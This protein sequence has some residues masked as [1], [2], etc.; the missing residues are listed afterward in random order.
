MGESY[1]G[2]TLIIAIIDIILWS[3]AFFLLYLVALSGFLSLIITYQCLNKLGHK[4]RK[5]EEYRLN[6]KYEHLKTGVFNEIGKFIMGFTIPTIVLGTFI[7]IIGLF[8]IFSGLLISG[9]IYIISGLVL[10]ALIVFLLYRNTLKIHYAITDTKSQILK[11]VAK[12]IQTL[13]AKPSSEIELPQKYEA[14]LN[15]VSFYDS[16]EEITDWPFDPASI[17]KLLLTLASS[18]VPLGLS[19]FGLG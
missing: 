8:Y 11:D 2:I 16:V 1:T 4:K 6:I 10:D 3:I 14:L 19:L 7:S 5:K 18:V 13:N 17:K 9:Y 12:D 15:L